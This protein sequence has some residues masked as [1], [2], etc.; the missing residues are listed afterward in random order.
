M[1]KL[2]SKLYK[3]DNTSIVLR[4]TLLSGIVK[5]GSLFIA[6]FTTPSYMRYF[7]NDEILG[8]W[9][10]I[11]SVL[12]W[13]L[14][15]DMG[16]GNGLRNNLVYAINQKDWIK[17]KKYISSS[18]LFLS[19]VGVLILFITVFVGSFINWNK[20]F[21]ISTEVLASNELISAMQ[22]LLASI[23]LQFILRLVT[24]ICYALQ[25]S[26]IPGFLNLTTNAMMLLF[27]FYCNS[28]GNN[29]NNIVSLAWAYLLAV[30]LPLVFASF[31]V[32]CNRIPNCIPSFRFFRKEYA[33]SILKVGSAFLLVQLISMVIDNTSNYLITMFIGNSAVVEFQIYNKIFT[34]PMTLVML[35]TTSMWSTLTKA[36]SENDW[37]WIAKGYQ[38][39]KQIVLIIGLMEFLSIIPL[40]I[41]FNLWL[42]DQSINVDYGI[43][44]VFAI[45]GT[46][47][48]LRVILA[49][50]SNGLCE[51]RIQIIYIT[52][53]AIIYIPLSYFFSQILHSYVAI[54]IA[55]IISILPFC[56]AQMK[57]CR[58]KFCTYNR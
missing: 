24:S 13:I 37:N 39:C 51:L 49:N 1:F 21:N 54:V 4:N 41:V 45:Y 16:I 47:M 10:T 55:N 43:A 5:G 25:E 28:I 19:G 52:L 8:V 18:Y 6:L 44:F 3:N 15:C 27:V 35:V 57:W 23:I 58:E 33:F 26:F 30:N 50:Y 38:K 53:G 29:N 9:F 34:L 22:I 17:A 46:L 40:Q 42:G 31:W 11:L 56:I 32:F 36:K 20:F 48:C 2:K 12:A 14:N 7:E